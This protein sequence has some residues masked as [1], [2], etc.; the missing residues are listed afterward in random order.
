MNLILIVVLPFPLGWFV[1]H[2]LAAYVTYFAAFNFLFTF[3]SVLLITK[4]LGG[5]K[6]AFGGFPKAD[7]GDVYSYGVVNLLLFVAGL[8]LLALGSYLATRRRTPH[9]KPV[10]AVGVATVSV[11]SS[12][13][14][15]VPS[16]S[17]SLSF[18]PGHWRD[19]SRPWSL[20]P[21]PATT[22]SFFAASLH[23][24]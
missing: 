3:Q 2:R 13:S 19:P 21:H 24:C 7:S 12:R 11:G 16:G 8:G 6:N 15:Q 20:F 17:G 18:H 22:A 4:W 9:P 1:R 10:S 14:F 5:S 23:P